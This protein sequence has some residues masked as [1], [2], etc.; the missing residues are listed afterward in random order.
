[1]QYQKTD[2]DTG[3]RRNVQCRS[4]YHARARA[5]GL[6]R[7]R[8]DIEVGYRRFTLCRAGWWQRDFSLLDEGHLVGRIYPRHWLSAR[9]C[10]ELPDEFEPAVVVFLFWLVLICWRRDGSV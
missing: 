10:I 1:M 5:C 7:G 9:A 6:W 4:H 8:Y 3:G 2:H